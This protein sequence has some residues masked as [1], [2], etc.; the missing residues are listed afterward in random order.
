MAPNKQL[1]RTVIRRRV[2]A[3]SAPFHY[4]LAARWT[5]RR[6]AAQLRRWLTMQQPGPRTVVVPPPGAFFKYRWTKRRLL[7]GPA[8]GLAQVLA[9]DD[10]W[11]IA[12]LRVLSSVEELQ[13]PVSIEFLPVL[14]SSVEASV[15][16]Q[17]EQHPVPLAQ[18]WPALSV[19]RELHAQGEA[20]AFRGHVFEAVEATWETVRSGSADRS[21]SNSIVEYSFP[22]K[23]G[24]STYSS[25]RVSVRP[26]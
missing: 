13:D 20:G 23:G 14:M 10:A 7:P 8:F 16:S 11:G 26:R 5:P 21:D 3:A 22:V 18:Y 4:A 19:W 9:F 12:F 24:A 1:E 15:L 25:V 6:A 2:R 17:L